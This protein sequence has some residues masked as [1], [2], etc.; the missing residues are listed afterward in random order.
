MENVDKILELKNRL[1]DIDA[2]E[3]S[4]KMT[5]SSAD[6]ND[7]ELKRIRTNHK[8]IESKIHA[9]EKEIHTLESKNAASVERE[10]VSE[11]RKRD[12]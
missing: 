10:R 3:D 2:M 4:E 5:V 12:F 8:A 6:K 7:H 1:L 9:L 11:Q